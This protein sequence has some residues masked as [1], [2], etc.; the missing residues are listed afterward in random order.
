MIDFSSFEANQIRF[1]SLTQ[2]FI[3]QEEEASLINNFKN[4]FKI[5]K[6]EVEIKHDE[7]AKKKTMKELIAEAL[8]E[9]N[10]KKELLRKQLDWGALEVM[11]P[12]K[13]LER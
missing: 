7:G 3:L 10:Q 2:I 4:S 9:K 12:K 8:L 13:L 1:Q 5:R 6:E 11:I